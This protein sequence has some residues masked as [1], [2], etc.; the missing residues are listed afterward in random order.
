MKLQ[1]E[2][3]PTAQ[4]RQ[5]LGIELVAKEASLDGFG[6]QV[7]QEGR[8][9]WENGWLEPLDKYIADKELTAP[10]WD[11][12]DFGAGARSAQQIPSPGATPNA[13]GLLTAQ[14][15]VFY[16]RTDLFQEAGLKPPKTFQE[17]EE[18]AKAL[19]K[20]DKQQYGITLRG[21]GKWAT[22]QIGT[23]LYGFGGKW[24]GDDG[25][26]ALDT[27]EMLKTLE[28]YGGL[29]RNYGPPGASNIDDRGNPAV[30][31]QGQAAMMTELNHWKVILNDPSKSPKVAGKIA[32]TYIPRGPV[33]GPVPGGHFIMLPVA[34][35]GMSAYGKHKEATWLFMQWLV[36]KQNEVRRMLG[37]NSSAR[38]S[39]W[40]AKEFLD[41]PPA[42]ANQDWLDVSQ[43][44]IKYG[45]NWVSPPILAVDEFRDVLAK[46]IDAAVLGS[47]P[48]DKALKEVQ[49]EADA[50]I[51]R[52]EQKGRKLVDWSKLSKQ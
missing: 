47:P 13:V 39:A 32:A 8:Q 41:T 23:Y 34:N 35:Q 2:G 9:Y 43:G 3:I 30:L 44:G 29:L 5:K 17:L 1:Y 18:A 50:L 52:T 21:S 7:S 25:R 4:A 27:P 12:E 6:I 42:K 51:E 36:N 49:T 31:Q 33:E 37:G 38:I 15:Q 10:D 48:L 19:H 20:P 22:T 11:F 14:C 45:R 24:I 16:Y 28:L 46:A 26:L 40:S